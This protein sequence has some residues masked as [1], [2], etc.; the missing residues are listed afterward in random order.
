MP[1]NKSMVLFGA[2]SFLI[3]IFTLK[4]MKKRVGLKPEEYSEIELKYDSRV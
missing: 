3:I 1:T 2:L 4:Y